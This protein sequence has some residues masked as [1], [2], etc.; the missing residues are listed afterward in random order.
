MK[1]KKIAGADHTN[2]VRK[3]QCIPVRAQRPSSK[4]AQTNGC[5]PF[6]ATDG[7]SAA[8]LEIR[9]QYKLRDDYVCAQVK[10]DTQIKRIVS[11][12]TGAKKVEDKDVKSFHKSLTPNYLI[13]RAHLDGLLNLRD[14]A[15]ANREAYEKVLKP[16]VKK[17]PI[18]KNFAK[19]V[20]GF[21]E[22]GLCAIIAEAGAVELYPEYSSV[23][24]LW[25]RF[26]L[27]IMDGAAF[28]TL[29]GRKALSK[30][31]WQAAGYSPSRRAVMHW[32]V[33]FLLM[34]KKSP[35]RDFY[36]MRKERE[37]EKATAEGLS[38]LPSAKLEKM[39]PEERA[40]YRS[41]GHIHARAQR[42]VG[43]KL[44]KDLWRAWRDQVNLAKSS[45]GRHVSPAFGDAQELADR[46]RPL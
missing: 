29:R 40:K 19:G 3:D 2:R 43:K 31:E 45:H 12:Y 7:M 14:L 10:L 4:S 26:G 22:M 28:S 5:V 23:P 6:A 20:C 16:L 17:L 8:L 35:Y 32:V 33:T 38:V 18:W 9:E 24:K 15:F 21:G 11:R 41:L 1:A 27:H 42:A 37:I 44:L 46:L 34:Q 39:P 25:K 13:L 30:K 36:L